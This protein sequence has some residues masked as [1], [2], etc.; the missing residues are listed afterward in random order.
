MRG[1]FFSA[2][3][4]A[5]VSLSS[6]SR[7]PTLMSEREPST[8]TLREPGK[9][10]VT[11]SDNRDVRSMNDFGIAL[12]TAFS[13]FAPGGRVGRAPGLAPASRT[14][15]GPVPEGG[16]EERPMGGS[17]PPPASSGSGSKGFFSVGPMPDTP[18]FAV[19][20]SPI[21]GTMQAAVHPAH[22]FARE[23]AQAASARPDRFTLPLPGPAG[24]ESSPGCGRR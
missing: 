7:I 20:P 4:L 17:F 8:C 23:D 16:E 14:A 24:H 6:T 18:S 1:A 19:N 10:R 21:P 2:P 9:G 11:S 12:M 13:P 5:G 3:K 15:R 22:A